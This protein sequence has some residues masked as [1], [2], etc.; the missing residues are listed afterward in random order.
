MEKDMILIKTNELLNECVNI[1]KEIETIFDNSE[2][3]SDAGSDSF[4]LN[5]LLDNKISDIIKLYEIMGVKKSYLEVKSSLN[6]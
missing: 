5:L 1:S 3:L 2:S 4:G 6:K